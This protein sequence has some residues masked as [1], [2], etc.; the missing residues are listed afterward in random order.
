MKELTYNTFKVE[1]EQA[2][3]SFVDYTKYVPFPLKFNNLLDEQLDEASIS[4]I[5]CPRANFQP[6]AKCRITIISGKD[7]TQ[8]KT[9]NMFVSSDKADETPIGSNRYNHELYL[10]EETKWLERFIVPATSF[11]N[12]VKR[13]FPD[14]QTFAPFY[15]ISRYFWHNNGFIKGMYRN[16][17][18]AS[19]IT[20]IIQPIPTMFS[21]SWLSSLISGTP[22]Q[23]V[24]NDVNNKTPIK[25]PYK[26]K[27]E[28]FGTEINLSTAANLYEDFLSQHKAWDSDWINLIPYISGWWTHFSKDDFDVIV[29]STIEFHRK[30]DKNPKNTNIIK[31][32]YTSAN[33]G[34]FIV[35]ITPAT[36]TDT[37]VIPI[38]VGTYIDPNTGKEEA[39]TWLP[40]I[41]VSKAQTLTLTYSV[42]YNSQETGTAW[43]SGFSTSCKVFVYD[44]ETIPPKWNAYTVINRLLLRAEMLKKGDT[45]RFSIDGNL[46]DWLKSIETPE[47]NISECTLREALKVVGSYIH[48]EPRL[49]GNVITFDILGSNN[50]TDF[51]FAA[52]PYSQKDLQNSI[53]QF[54][55]SISSTVDNIVSTVDYNV[56]AIVEP[57]ND[58]YKTVRTENVFA[59]IQDDNMVIETDFP[60]QKV[61][62]LT[63]AV[64]LGELTHG[65]I[66]A[67]TY[68]IVDITNYVYEEGDY[69]RLSSYDE[70]L[71]VSRNYAL[72]YTINEKNIHG[73]NFKNLS[74][75]NAAL[76]EYAII[77]ILRA[78][79]SKTTLSTDLIETAINNL[80]SNYP[81]LM[82]NLSYAPVTGAKMRQNK[83]YTGFS[84]RPVETLYNQTA[85]LIESKYYGEHLKGV[86]ARLGN[87][88]K[89][90]TYIRGDIKTPKIGDLYRE[91]NKDYYITA[92]ATE[93]Q[94]SFIKTTVALSEDFNRYSDYIAA[95]R[96]RRLFNISERQAYDSYINFRDFVVIETSET[97]EIEAP[98]AEDKAFM[99]DMRGQLD[100]LLY[101]SSDITNTV[102][103]AVIT[104]YGEDD[105]SNPVKISSCMLPLRRFP[106]GNSIVYTFKFLD[107]YAAGSTVT[108]IDG[109]I[110][111]GGYFQNQVAYKDYYG[112]IEYMAVDFIQNFAGFFPDGQQVYYPQNISV[113]DNQALRYHE[114]YSYKEQV[115]SLFE[116]KDELGK[117]KLLHVSIGANEI[118]TF[119]YQV[120]FVSND[121]DLI[122]GSRLADIG[123]TVTTKGRTSKFYWLLK[124][125]NK[126][127][128]KVNVN[129][130]SVFVQYPA[131]GNG[132]SFLHQTRG[133]GKSEQYPVIGYVSNQ[134]TVTQDVKGWVIVD[135]NNRVLMG[136]N[137]EYTQNQTFYITFKAMRNF[138]K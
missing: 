64:P 13:E 12:P 127:T 49:N 107:N 10:I 2:A 118:P 67:L 25:S 47:F 122:I 75:Y 125:L 48:A 45:P 54:S 63:C 80:K 105:N 55:S 103:V 133:E 9:I 36:P 39:V 82:F 29:Q 111:V 106:S 115:G 116:P 90:Y 100:T 68:Q 16:K 14:T 88:S 3:E 102:S 38:G 7:T 124:P 134:L 91:N 97:G 110:D 121:P 83:T 34:D 52:M 112:N 77:K 59:R 44:E 72:Y 18:Y 65:K 17:N 56:G 24:I 108:Y 15:E 92:V 126:F 43:Y 96:E 23:L 35:D 76:V 130:T 57:Y 86:I 138:Y 117:D 21:K 84:Y 8:T 22:Y 119:T 28:G 98:T 27:T 40:V 6:F 81:K 62:S 26:V 51:N 109:N 114:Y 89:T 66:N 20:T 78:E 104:T 46:E 33:N 95:N 71:G 4:L 30:D 94:P 87:V 85:N 123:G 32:K 41:Y 11:V 120:E 79:L 131:Y 93:L 128:E 1:I 61:L 37:L 73:L 70:G 113:E 19:E 129:D 101:N 31:Q 74:P 42:R 99:F 58:M 136:K 135:N 60:I 132:Q 137:G 69:L 50:E 5:K 53:E